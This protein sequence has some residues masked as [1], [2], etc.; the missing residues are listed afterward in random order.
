[1]AEINFNT[2]KVSASAAAVRNTAE[3]LN[4]T[5]KKIDAAID[6]I[7]SGWIGAGSEGYINYLMLIKKDLTLRVG[8]LSETSDMLKAS[9]DNAVKT[10]ALASGQ[11]GNFAGQL[12][13]NVKNRIDGISRAFINASK[14]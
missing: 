5:L 2:E 14:K 11:G 7:R 3:S 6:D 13:D 10:D 4:E 1:M 9:V 8:K 12:T